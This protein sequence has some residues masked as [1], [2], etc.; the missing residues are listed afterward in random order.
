LMNPQTRML[1]ALWKPVKTAYYQP[2]TAFQTSSDNM[3]PVENV[4]R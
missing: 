4:W 3:I 1:H 2:I